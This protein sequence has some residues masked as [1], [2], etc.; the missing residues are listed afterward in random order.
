MST[1]PPERF[2]LA[3]L[4][5]EASPSIFD[6]ESASENLLIATTIVS[7]FSFFPVN[8]STSPEILFASAW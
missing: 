7:R 2:S 3:S 8:S 6:S 1:R 4:R 5:I